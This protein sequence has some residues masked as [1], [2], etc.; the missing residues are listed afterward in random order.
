[1]QQKAFTR[2]P[3]RR[4]R[5]LSRSVLTDAAVGAAAQDD[6][7]R[8]AGVSRIFDDDGAVDDHRGARAARIAMGMRISRLVPE[9]IGIKDCDVG[10]VALLQESALTQFE[11]R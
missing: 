3:R 11:R 6:P 8:R 9:I 10:A 7:R 5:C 1:M 2:S 4:P